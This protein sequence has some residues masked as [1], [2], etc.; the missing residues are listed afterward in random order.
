VET[1]H[2]ETPFRLAGP[3]G[4]MLI[5]PEDTGELAAILSL[6]RAEV[7]KVSI[8]RSGKLNIEFDNG[9]ELSVDPDERYEA[10]QLG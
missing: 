4:E 2:I 9:R 8:R 1:L 7:R 10:W 3:D 6:F 5:D